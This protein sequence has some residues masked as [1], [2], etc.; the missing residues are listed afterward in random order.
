M[1]FM[2]G[3][4]VVHPAS[5]RFIDRFCCFL[6][7]CEAP[8][9][10]GTLSQSPMVGGGGSSSWWMLTCTSGLLYVVVSTAVS[11]RLPAL[12]GVLPV[13]DFA[14]PDSS[15]VQRSRRGATTTATATGATPPCATA[16][17]PGLVQSLARLYFPR[18]SSMAAQ[19]EVQIPSCDLVC[20]VSLCYLHI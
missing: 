19:R 17:T 6:C 1:V 4:P 9:R 20:C 2:H 18:I 16:A 8:R 12:V 5:A 3:H 14:G 13:I 11:D 15:V 10:R 7:L